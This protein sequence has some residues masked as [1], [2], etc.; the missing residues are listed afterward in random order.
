M[1][2]DVGIIGC[3][4]SSEVV[5]QKLLRCVGRRRSSG[6]GLRD[7]GLLLEGM[8]EGVLE[9][10]VGKRVS[11][12]AR[13]PLSGFVGRDYYVFRS[14]PLKDNSYFEIGYELRTVHGFSNIRVSWRDRDGS[15]VALPFEM[16]E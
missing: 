9:G 8:L 13:D 15:L 7:M 16:S 10:T 5:W 3:D 1:T 6:I 12:G 14:V 11:S 4:G 2:Y